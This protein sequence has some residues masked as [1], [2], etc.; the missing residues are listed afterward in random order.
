MYR[1]RARA[2]MGSSD[3]L[4]EAARRCWERMPA[5]GQK[6]P[7]RGWSCRSSNRPREI[8]HLA[9]LLHPFTPALSS[10]AYHR[11]AR[12]PPSLLL[13]LFL[14]LSLSLS[15]SLSLSLPAATLNSTIRPRARCIIVRPHRLAPTSSTCPEQ[16]SA[17]AHTLTSTYLHVRADTGAHE[18]RRV[19]RGMR[20][21]YCPGNV[22]RRCVTWLN[23]PF[24]TPFPPFLPPL[25]GSNHPRPLSPHQPSHSLSAFLSPQP[26]PILPGGARLPWLANNCRR[27]TWPPLISA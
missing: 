23:C 21:H 27:P 6:L 12:F 24:P 15:F 2:R 18:C 4:R 25:V 9:L 11:P 1:H 26:P 20:E 7:L 3:N 5:N 16:A 13:S 10:S 8:D 14:S 22:P 19:L 17:L